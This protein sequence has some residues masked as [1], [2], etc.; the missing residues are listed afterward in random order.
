M[1]SV[2]TM[3][4]EIDR[5]RS[6]CT[7]AMSGRADLANNLGCLLLARGDTAEAQ[8]WLERAVEINPKAWEFHR[9]LAAAQLQLGHPDAALRSLRNARDAAP[10]NIDALLPLL[11]AFFGRGEIAE[12]VEA[13][14]ILDRLLKST[15]LNVVTRVAL[16]NLLNAHRNLIGASPPLLLLWSKLEQ[17]LSMPLAAAELIDRLLDICPDHLE[18]WR[19]RGL[20]KAGGG[21]LEESIACMRRVTELDQNDWAAWNDAGCCLRTLGRGAEAREWMQRAV[22]AA[23]QRAVLHANLALLDFELNDYEACAAH[24]ADALVCDTANPEALHTKAMLLTATGRYSEAELV[25]REALSIKPDYPAARLGL[26]L[27][28]LTRGRL[29][30]GFAGYESRWVGSDRAEQQKQPTLGRPQWHGQAMLPGGTIAI[31][32]EQGFGDQLQFARFVPRLLDHFDR[33]LW[34]VPQELLRLFETSFGSERL[35][36][37]SAIDA[38][39]ARSVD[40]ELPLLS[41]G[42][43]LGI[44]LPDLPGL[45]PDSISYLAAPPDRAEHWRSRLESFDGLKVGIAWQGRPTLSKNALRNCPGELFATLAMPGVQLISLQRDADLPDPALALPWGREC[46]DFAD[47]AALVSCLDLVISVDTALVHLAGG[48]GVPVWMLNRLG[49]E[50]RWMEG[51]EDS[52]WYLSLRLFNQAVFKNWG[53]TVERVRHALETRIKGEAETAEPPSALPKPD[54]GEIRQGRQA[55]RILATRHG[56]L[57]YNRHDQYVGGSLAHYGEYSE[58]EV[59]LFRQMISPGDVVVEAGANIGALTVPLAKLVGSDGVVHAFEPQRLIFQMLCGSLA[60]NQCHNVVAHELGLGRA[61]SR[62]ATPRVDPNQPN[63]FG[64]LSLVNEGEGDPVKVVTLDSL[65]LARCRLIKADVEGMEE[66]V[67]L[68]ALETIARCRPL[69]YLENDRPERSPAL[70]RRLMDLDYRIWWHCPP[71]FNPDNF[72]KNPYN[73]FPN[74]VS[75]NVFCQPAEAMKPIHGLR[76]IISADESP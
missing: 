52:P 55:N 19:E 24:L 17:Q 7:G 2:T 13:T 43:V 65:Q 58:G 33:V 36:L 69:L 39:L 40:V 4:D 56:T 66:D 16:R 32:P 37:V 45:M 3:M 72:F 62:M 67:I 14:D 61:T 68:G 44:D 22:A 53:P 46:T 34:Q 18:G 54:S 31:L 26:A 75:F 50:W 48:L 9:N 42:L 15:S 51:R 35:Q 6:L 8:R 11:D 59:D 76:E 70:L 12:V 47:T 38:N 23:P 49:S 21:Q 25:D 1:P 29:K 57:I 41:L 27:T 73:M 63:N 71:L 20:L 28:F 60:L 64:G 5:L 10:D 74:M 30:E